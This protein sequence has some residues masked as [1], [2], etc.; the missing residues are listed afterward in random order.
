VLIAAYIVKELPVRAV[1]WLVVGVVVYTALAML[2]SA[3]REARKEA[4]PHA[5]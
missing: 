4:G 1:Q 2:R 3:R 5:A